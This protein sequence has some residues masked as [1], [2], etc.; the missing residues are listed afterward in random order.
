MDKLRFS[1]KTLILTVLL[2]AVAVGA[3]MVLTPTTADA[4]ING[5]Y[6]AFYQSAGHTTQVGYF[7]YDCSCHLVN[8]GGVVTS[9]FTSN[10]SGCGEG[11]QV[12]YPMY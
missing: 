3:V 5:T 11:A 2:I 9:Y 6:V 12:C 10:T 1:S 7:Q 8:S 4:R